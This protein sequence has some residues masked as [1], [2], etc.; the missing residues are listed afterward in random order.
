M[1]K[2]TSPTKTASSSTTPTKLVAATPSRGR[3]LQEIVLGFENGVDMWHLMT[4]LPNDFKAKCDDL[5]TSIEGWSKGLT[6]VQKSKLPQNYQNLSTAIYSCIYGSNGVNYLVT[7]R[8]G[9]DNVTYFAPH[10]AQTLIYETM[11]ARKIK[12]ANHDVKARQTLS[13]FENVLE[14]IDN[15]RPLITNNTLFE[16]L[17]HFTDYL[18]LQMDCVKCA[19]DYKKSELLA[20]SEEDVTNIAESIDISDILKHWHYSPKA[21]VTPVKAATPHRLAVSEHLKENKRLRKE[22]EVEEE[23]VSGEEHEDNA[24]LGLFVNFGVD[25]EASLPL[26]FSSSSSS[27]S[28]SESEESEESEEEL[29]SQ[30]PQRLTSKPQATT[31]T[32]GFA[33]ARVSP[34]EYNPGPNRRNLTNQFRG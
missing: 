5:Q 25:P 17:G 23:S 22:S 14:R 4:T 3:Y 27:S 28:S 32:P 9:L 18:D 31:L 24:E 12:D 13:M 1:L 19:L 30:S 33:A 8:N 7:E 10:M 21:K 29:L 26:R 2:A 6:R 15:F 20:L 11:S 34:N 16:K